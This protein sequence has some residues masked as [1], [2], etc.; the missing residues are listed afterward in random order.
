MASTAGD[1][2]AFELAELRGMLEE[3]RALYA[4][5]EQDPRVLYYLGFGPPVPAG[6]PR[7][8]YPWNAV[9]P[10]SDSVVNLVMPGNLREAD[11]AYHNYAVLRMRE[12]RT[13][14]PDDPCES[15]V[16]REEKV[17]SGFVDGWVLARTLFGGP[18]YAPLDELAF[19]REAG[20]LAALL[21]ARGDAAVGACAAAWAEAHP[22]AVEAYEAW[23]G[24]AFPDLVVPPPG[25]GEDVTPELPEEPGGGPPV[26]PPGEP[27]PTEF[28]GG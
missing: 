9:Q 16:A 6:S 17:L 1:T 20:H 13:G 18:A 21:A 19:A 14:D 10:Q 7:P 8:A 4:D 11:R 23:R 27:D 26:P 3:A 15:L 12:I 5:L 28:P 22:G 2:L 24:G 25:P